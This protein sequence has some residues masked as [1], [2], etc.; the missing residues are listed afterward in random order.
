MQDAHAIKNYLDR[1][2]GH[3]RVLGPPAS[4]KTTLLVERYR[5]LVQRGHQPGV[6][7]FGRAQQDRLLDAILPPGTAI[8][9]AS[10]VTTH[11]LLASSILSAANPS[12]LRTLRDVDELIVLGRLL[13]REPDLLTSDLAS[14]AGSTTLLRDVLE[15]VHVL[16]QQ[17]LTAAD[18]RRCVQHCG[19]ARARDVLLVFAEY[20]EACA[21]RGVTTF[22]DAAW[23]AAERYEAGGIPSPLADFDVVLIDDFQDLDPGQFHLLMKLAAP[24]GGTSVEVFGDPTGPRFSFRGTTDWFLSEVFPRVYKPAELAL[25]PAAASDAA[26][27]DVVES[28]IAMTSRGTTLVD[29]TSRSEVA[30]PAGRT[31]DVAPRPAPARDGAERP[32][33]TLD[34]PLFQQPSDSPPAHVSAPPPVHPGDSPP[35]NASAPLPAHPGDSPPANASDSSRADAR[36]SSVRATLVMAD[37]E[38][39]EAQH[40]A[41]RVRRALD[42]GVTAREIAVIAREPERYRSALSLACHDWGVPLD[43][44]GD[45]N[46]AVDAFLRSLLGA[47]GND[48]DGRFAETLAASPVF[49]LLAESDAA[50]L[51]RSW[52]RQYERRSGEFDL[53]ALVRERVTPLFAGSADTENA[54]RNGQA[55]DPAVPERVTPLFA[56]SPAARASLT[57]VID[58]WRR[59]QEVIARAG[60]SLD[61]FRV[62]YLHESAP[63]ASASNSIAL[64]SA[65]EAS[66]REFAMVFVVGCAEGFFPGGPARSGYIPL[67]AIARALEPVGMDI[68]S[69]VARRVDHQ[70]ARRHETALFLTALTRARDELVISTPARIGGEAASPSRI[71]EVETRG[72]ATEEAPRRESPCARATRAV[73]ATAPDEERAQKLRAFDRLAGWW[74]SAKGEA[75]YPARP[76]FTMSASKLN[77]HAR[78]ARKFFY[79]SVLKIKEPE[80]IYLQVGS[81]VHEALKEIIP[82]GATGDEVRAALQHAG[83]REISER[84]VSESFPDAS[85]WK[86][87]L[88]VKYLEDMLRD[89]AALEAQREGNYR[90]RMLEEEVKGDVEGMPM[91]GRMDRVDDVEGLGAVVIDYKISGS[92]D[93]SC[94]TVLK[95]MESSYWQ[96]P[97]YAVMARFK[98]V[99]PAA[100]VYYALPPGDESHATGVQ[101][102]PGP[103][104]PPIPIGRS[105]QHPRFGHA[106]QEDIVGAMTRAVEL[107]RSIVEGENA[108]QRTDNEQICPN[109]HFA[110]ICQRSR[111]SV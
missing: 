88:S 75:R 60:T 76:N 34:L 102:A 111:A 104:R 50:N 61:E 47:L 52:R 25:A 67:A 72:F 84:L 11:A 16:A 97:V 56:D 22:Y 2:P 77:S 49:P 70:A 15:V 90:V 57:R 18:A 71:L 26:L 100:F 48:T 53:E 51:V 93:K 32:A 14:I 35:A 10:P 23:R 95:K 87:E 9:G 89:V 98:D 69:E 103:L 55:A 68:A 43:A 39:A 1:P 80:S 3:A 8:L 21:E 40:V 27:A 20:T 64:L 66:G 38:I 65:R 86:R 44:G 7:A 5:A 13:R 4:G 37:D 62:H 74:V 107:Y 12:R 19:N 92:V 54:R 106:S 30:A 110:R 85:G 29:A 6:I 73:A 17:G 24:D 105:K 42:A 96:L 79:S 81:L 59:Y 28:L 36:V 101:L 46:G 108:Y 58:D 99:E 33:P 45:A 82:A 91:N 63:R 78:C 109:C 83:T 41:E 31:R 94:G